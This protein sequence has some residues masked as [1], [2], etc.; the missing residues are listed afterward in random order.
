MERRK[1]EKMKRWK[2]DN[3]RVEQKIREKD[4][5]KV[6]ILKQNKAENSGDLWRYA[7]LISIIDTS[8]KVEYGIISSTANKLQ[9]N[10]RKNHTLTWIY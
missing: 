6:N 5:S 4:W 10:G 2:D 3:I 7:D 9:K 8:R 1:D